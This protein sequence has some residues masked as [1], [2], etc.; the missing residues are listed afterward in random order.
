[1]LM[2]RQMKE[3]RVTRST[4]TTSL[5]AVSAVFS[6]GLL[7]GCVATV[8]STEDLSAAFSEALP[9]VYIAASDGGQFYFKMMPAPGAPRDLN[10]GSGIAYSA[11]LMECDTELWRVDGWYSWRVFLSPD[12]QF[13][14]RLGAKPRIDDPRSREQ[15]GL[16]M[17]VRGGLVASYSIDEM[18]EGE[19]G[20][21]PSATHYQ[22]WDV[23][24]PPRFFLAEGRMLFSIVSARGT[25][26]I[27]DCDT[28]RIVSRG[29]ARDS[30]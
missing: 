25:K 10:A 19:E 27:I 22:Y 12:G 26:F 2:R 21:F 15:I 9:H 7:G 5:L 1:M 11:S 30:S 23:L 20:A 4:S 17:Y 28:G 16:A 8:R 3:M 6:A 14:V 24:S 13:L 29:A 18:L